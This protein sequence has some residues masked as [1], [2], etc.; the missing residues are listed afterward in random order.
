MNSHSHYAPTTGGQWSQHLGLGFAIG[1]V[2]KQWSF[3]EQLPWARVI[4]PVLQRE[5]LSFSKFQ[6][7]NCTEPR[8]KQDRAASG[9][10]SV[11]N[12]GAFLL[13]RAEKKSLLWS[14]E[15]LLF[16]LGLAPL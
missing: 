15:F 4:L 6:Q 1:Q 7:R 14:V 11:L 3:T 12:H 13:P 8:T 2:I 9:C 16:G 10:F 5:K